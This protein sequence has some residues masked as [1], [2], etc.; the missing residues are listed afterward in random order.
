MS[1]NEPHQMHTLS[2]ILWGLCFAKTTLPLHQGSTDQSRSTQRQEY[3]SSLNS[4]ERSIVGPFAQVRVETRPSHTDTRL[5]WSDVADCVAGTVVNCMLCTS[6]GEVALHLWWCQQVVVSWRRSL[7]AWWLVLNGELGSTQ[8]VEQ[9]ASSVVALFPAT[10]KMPY[11]SLFV[12]LCMCANFSGRGC[13]CCGGSQRSPAA[14][15]GS[16]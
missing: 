9:L 14:L 15:C 5:W 11:T 3:F 6:M 10:F 13:V 1:R 7:P 4:M 12:Y 2:V 16:V 8:Q